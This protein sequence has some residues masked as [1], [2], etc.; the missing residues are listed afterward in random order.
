MIKE[1]K[2]VDK[3]ANSKFAIKEIIVPSWFKRRIPNDYDKKSQN[4]LEYY[5]LPEMVSFTTNTFYNV[6][7]KFDGIDE[8]KTQG[9]LIYNKQFDYWLIDCFEVAFKIEKIE[10]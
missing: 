1:N 3:S 4:S 9:R 5:N 10:H 6:S 2:I 7:Y 8:V